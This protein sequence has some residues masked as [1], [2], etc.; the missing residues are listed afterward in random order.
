MNVSG[1][2]GG[3]RSAEKGGGAGGARRA[4][5]AAGL[6]GFLAVYL[7]ANEVLGAVAVSVVLYAFVHEV[8][9]D[10]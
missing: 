9:S 5:V 3:D 10:G 4:A 2:G 1:E 6:L 8:L 7:L